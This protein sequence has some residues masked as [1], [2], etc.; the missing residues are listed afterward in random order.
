MFPWQ[1]E[2]ETDDKEV[3]GIVEKLSKNLQ[4]ELQFEIRGNILKN[5]LVFQK[6]STNFVKDCTQIMNEVR[7][8]PEEEIFS[9][10]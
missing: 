6:F 9:E 7:F 2:K 10:N 5:A 8:S 1:E 4:E 3:Q